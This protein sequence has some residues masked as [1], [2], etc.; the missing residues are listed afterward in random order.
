VISNRFQPVQWR[1]HPKLK[2]RFLADHPN[3]LLVIVHEGGPQLTARRPEAVL[4]EVTGCDGEV[5]TGRVLHQPIQV[6]TVR[7]G[8]QIRF[9]VPAAARYPVLVTERYLHER[10]N[11]KIQPCQKCGFSELFDAPSELIR[12]LRPNSA[13]R[14]GRASF[15]SPCP[16]CGGTQIVSAKAEIREPHGII[17]KK[18]TR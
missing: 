18:R 13:H 3:E 9:V 15:K 16:L 11:W 6:H 12:I 17:A 1:A 2:G 7:L 14:A 10:P 8:Q 4:V 5:F